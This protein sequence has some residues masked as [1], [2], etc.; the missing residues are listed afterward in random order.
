MLYGTA[1]KKIKQLKKKKEITQL[2]PH[3]SPKFF[4]GFWLFSFMPGGLDLILK[5]SKSLFCP[6]KLWFFLPGSPLLQV[7][8]PPC[9]DLSVA[10]ESSLPPIP[11]CVTRCL[12]TMGIGLPVP[13][14]CWLVVGLAGRRTERGGLSPVATPFI[15]LPTRLCGCQT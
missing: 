6:W 15:L 2:R 12:W 14:S 13:L 7:V 10:G 1:N 3:Q 4:S 5:V 8:L 9:S 11:A